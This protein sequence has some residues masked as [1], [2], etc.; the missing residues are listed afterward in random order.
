MSG[1]AVDCMDS[2]SI[3]LFAIREITRAC[4][5]YGKFRHILFFYF[6][7]KPGV[8]SRNDADLFIVTI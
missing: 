3:L 6:H 2:V 1:L 5:V 4:I 8:A 7:F